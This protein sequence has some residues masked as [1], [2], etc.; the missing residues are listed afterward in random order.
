MRRI[1][2]LSFAAIA[3]DLRVVRAD[4][5]GERFELLSYAVHVVVVLAGNDG[6]VVNVAADQ[7]L[8]FPS[9][10]PG[11]SLAANEAFHAASATVLRKTGRAPACSRTA[12]MPASS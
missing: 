6:G 9:H 11:F 1:Q 7:D 4:A 12:F 8:R 3:A 10:P 5:L 2:Y